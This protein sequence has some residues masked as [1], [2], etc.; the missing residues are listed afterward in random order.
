MPQ[1]DWS[2]E[3]KKETSVEFDRLKLKRDE[4]ARIAVLEKPTFAWVH[5]L[6]AP[7]IVNGEA[8]KTTKERNNGE[9]YVD[10]DMDFI[11]RPLC[12]GDYG[13]IAD[14]GSDPDNCPACKMAKT[15]DVNPPERR[16][17]VNVIRYN[18][19]REGKLMNPFSCVCV[20]WT[21]TDT[22]YNKLTDIVTEYGPMHQRDLIL[23]PCTNE[24]FQK[25]EIMPAAQAAWNVNDEVKTLV[26][27]TFKENRVENLEAA[28]GRKVERRW[29]EEDLGK[30]QARWAIAN[31]TAHV[32]AQRDGT[33]AASAASLAEGM[34]DLLGG[35]PAP[36]AQPTQRAE[37]VDLDDMLGGQPSQPAPAPARADTSGLD[38]GDLMG[39]EQAAAPSAVAVKDKPAESTDFQKLLDELN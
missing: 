15:G 8:V 10:F 38:F 31:G 13:I 3:H 12:L 4:R 14:K 24:S 26:F 22:I 33:E 11:G 19:N 9:K 34:A 18:L 35:S 36:A 5:T 1:L 23:G 21:F 25:F 27:A 37:A 30:V 7:K 29:M 2:P 6:R 32:P 17:A 20:V 39:G 16:F 28:C